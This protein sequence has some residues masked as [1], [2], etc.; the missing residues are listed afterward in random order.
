MV[1]SEMK[2]KFEFSRPLLLA[3]AILIHLLAG[4][5][6]TDERISASR[7]PGETEAFNAKTSLRNL[8]LG[9]FHGFDAIHSPLHSLVPFSQISWGYQLNGENW[10]SFVVP[11]ASDKIKIVTNAN[12]VGVNENDPGARWRYAFD[13]EILD[14]HSNKPVKSGQYNFE[15]GLTRISLENME[16]GLTAAFYLDSPEIPADGKIFVINTKELSLAGKSVTLRFRLASFDH[17]ISSVVLRAY[18]QERLSERKLDFQ[19]MRITKR[20]KDVLSQGNVYPSEMLSEIEKQ[21]LMRQFWTP[22]SP[23]GIQGRDF[24]A[25][26]IYVIRDIESVPIEDPIIPEGILV[27]A[28]LRGTLAIPEDGRNVRLEFSHVGPSQAAKNSTLTINWYGP[29]ITDRKSLSLPWN[30]LALTWEGRF[31]GGLL[32]IMSETPMV[33][34]PSWISQNGSQAAIP[35]QLY[36]RTYVIDNSKSVVFKVAH[37]EGSVTPLRLDFRTLFEAALARNHV[38]NYAILGLK[39]E[40]VKE[41]KLGFS[42]IPSSY[43][44]GLTGYYQAVI[45]DPHSFYFRL[46][47]ESP[48]IKLTSEGTVA[49]TA[50][51]RPN[52]LIKETNVPQDYFQES[53]LLN[54][55]EPEWFNVRP[56]DQQNLIKSQNSI[57]AK[58]QLRPPEDDPD[59][60]AGRF[61]WEQFRPKGSWSGQ[62]ILVNQDKALSYNRQEALVSGFTRVVKGEQVA[63][64]LQSDCDLNV[65][66]PTIIFL[67]KNDQ[68][69]LRF[70]VWVDDLPLVNAEIFGLRGMFRLPPV[71]SGYHRLKIDSDEHDVS[72]LVNHIASSEIN[73]EVRFANIFSDGKMD[74]EYLKRSTKDEILSLTLYAP[75]GHSGRST[76]RV[77]LCVPQDQSEGPT[78]D[79]TILERRFRVTPSS[80]GPCPALNDPDCDLEA[81]QKMFFPVHGDIPP[82]NYNI[83]VELE[84]GAANYLELTRVLPGTFEQREFREEVTLDGSNTVF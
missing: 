76:I 25:R 20:Q 9:L 31:E 52:D 62:F 42:S 40:T 16:P 83:K 45:S 82:G 36:V 5:D 15:T 13:W 12:L 73:N 70:K 44:L 47:A 71:T 72:F 22:L 69:P 53:T 34:T 38:V 10:I 35:E 1:G 8:V 11:I 74:V 29:E 3:I 14:N 66:T 24:I 79:L 4:C 78:E 54:T 28:S 67:R 39:G 56:L 63:V 41:G 6:L 21:N 68:A 23:E 7:G 2:N 59:I 27:N 64:N 77:R 60:L 65:I 46:P 19:W 48:Y 26:K 49:A 17:G 30:G 51:T 43:D 50:Y 33:V 55:R 57:L 18:N 84:D 37:S 75:F 80:G 58:I 81:G 61:W 32:E